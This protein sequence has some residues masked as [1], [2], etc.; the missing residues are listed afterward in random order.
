[1]TPHTIHWP[2]AG[3][4][5]GWVLSLVCKCSWPGVESAGPH[6]EIPDPCHLSHMLWPLCTNLQTLSAPWPSH[7]VLLGHGLRAEI[8]PKTQHKCRRAEALAG[9]AWELW[10]LRCPPQVHLP[11]C[12]TNPWCPGLSPILSHISTVLPTGL[13]PKKGRTRTQGVTSL[14]PSDHFLL[15]S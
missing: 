1:M 7:A 4:L 9:L 2:L 14:H 6:T 13:H 15:L 8:H 5:P 3:L 12:A 11:G 10:P